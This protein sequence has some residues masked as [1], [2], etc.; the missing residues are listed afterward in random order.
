MRRWLWLRLTPDG[1]CEQK[2]ARAYDAMVKRHEAYVREHR[3]EIRA[4][5]PRRVV[6]IDCLTVGCRWGDPDSPRCECR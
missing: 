6:S 3:D 4:R 1:R 5:L 2:A